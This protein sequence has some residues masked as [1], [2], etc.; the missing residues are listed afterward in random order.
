MKKFRKLIILFFILVSFSV[1]AENRQILIPKFICVGDTLEIKYIFHSDAN[2]FPEEVFSKNSSH[3]QLDPEYPHFMAL[4]ESFSIKDIYIENSG[5]EY[6]LSMAIVPWKAGNFV[7]PPFD[8]TSLVNY[9][10]KSKKRGIT[11]I[12]SIDP[13]EVNS[14]LKQNTVSTFLPQSGPLLLPGTTIIIAAFAILFIVLFSALIYFAAKLPAF[15]LL[16]EKILYICSLKKNSRAAIKDLNK[17]LKKTGFALSD[18]EYAEQIQ[19][20]LRSFLKERFERD[21]QAI[22]TG[23]LYSEFVDISGGELMDF[24]EKAVEKTIEIFFRTDYI[25]FSKNAAFE[26]EERSKLTL[27]AIDLIFDFD[28]EKQKSENE[29]SL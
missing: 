20:I 23:K 9:S 29:E 17:L 16:I 1:H 15:A 2:I 26:N 12:V 8:L 4:Q 22:S 11:Y 24:Q 10:L 19:K 25:R 28:T 5:S 13:I 6:V 27:E 18:K 3:L 21:F 14:N 7:I